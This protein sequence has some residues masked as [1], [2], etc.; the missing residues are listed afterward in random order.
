MFADAPRILI[1]SAPF[2]PLLGGMERYAEDLASGLA[3]L[4]YDVQLA[5]RTP[6][7]P[8]ADADRFS[9]RVLRIARARELAAAMLRNDLT[10]FVG[11]TVLDVMLAMLLLRRFVVT[12]H[13]VYSL[14]GDT[15]RFSKGTVKRWMPRFFANISVSHYLA[16]CLAGRHTVIHNGYRDDL[17]VPGNAA[18]PPGSFIFVGRL[19]SDK[20]AE[21]LVR[22]FARLHAARPQAR[23]TIVGEG[24]ERA[25]LVQLAATLGCDDAIV[26][27]GG[28]PSEEVA[29]LLS[30][31]QCQVVPSVSEEPFGIVALEG[32][33]AG[34]EM[35]V[36]RRGGLPEATGGFGWI[37]DASA[38]AI[39]DAMSEVLAGRSMRREPA[40]SAFLRDHERLA[41]AGQYADALALLLPPRQW[42]D[43]RLRNAAAG[44]PPA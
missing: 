25:A 24:P 17:F 41:V 4:G 31:H 38:D 5:T 33:A 28:Q 18:R 10:L 32:L 23:L 6:P 22:G 1:Y 14:H 30:R 37:V 42:H 29:R 3:E 8:Q 20:G 7:G 35:I 40:V 9:F 26:F 2:Y 43:A 13:G 21:L 39:H 16:S 27:A 19:V 11:L 34:C 12:H 44:R 36:T 15:R